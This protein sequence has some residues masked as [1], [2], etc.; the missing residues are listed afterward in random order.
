MRNTLYSILIGILL[1]ILVIIVIDGRL[2]GADQKTRPFSS[3]VRLAVGD[4]RESLGDHTGALNEYLRIPSGDLDPKNLARLQYNIGSLYDS[5]HHYDDA[6]QSYESVKTADDTTAFQKS[7]NL[8]NDY[9]RMGEQVS[10]SGS[11]IGLW[12][13]ALDAYSQA[14]S[15]RPDDAWTIEN[16]NYVLSQLQQEIKKNTP[17]PPPQQHQQSNT[18]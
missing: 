16:Y 17:P 7:Y 3:Y 5:V 13:R 1:I 12:S 2:F 18:S 15:A 4:V 9:Y 8:G 14:R 10:D 6:R 11:R